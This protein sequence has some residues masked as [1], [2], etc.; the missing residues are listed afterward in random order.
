MNKSDLAAIVSQETG[1][2]Q[3]KTEQVIDSALNNIAKALKEDDRVFLYGFGTFETRLR[4]ARKGRNIKTGNAVDID[5]ERRA[6]FLAGEALKRMIREADE[7][8]IK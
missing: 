7:A 8:K 6:V 2:T 4:A 1:V 5:P 3:Y